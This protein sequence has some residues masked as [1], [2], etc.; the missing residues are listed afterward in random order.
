MGEMSNR[1]RLLRVLR[2]EPVDRIPVAPFIHINYVK[3]FFGSHEVDWVVKTP[4]VYK[5]FGF[6]TIHRN[7]SPVYDAYGPGTDT[8]KMKTEVQRDGR[9]ETKIT[10]ITTPGGPIRIQ[11]ELRW[12]CEYDAESSAVEYPIAGIED[13]ELFRRHQPPLEAADATDIRRA[14]DA[15]GKEGIVAPWIQGAFNLLALYYRKLDDLLLDPLVNPGFYARMMEHFLTRYMGFVQQLIDAGTDV[16]SYGANVANAKLISPEFYR[17]YIGPYEKR[18][19]DFIQSRGVIVLFHN[20][21]YARNFLSLYS[22]LGMQAY[23]SLAPRPYGDT[24][25]NEAVAAFGM[26]TALAG[27]IDQLDLLR[28]GT[29]QQIDSTVETICRTVRNRS[30]FILGTTDYFNEATPRENIHALAEAGR[31]HGGV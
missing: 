14:K 20:C 19:I 24:E 30:N 17:R 3:E 10:E 26:K 11:E 21:G 16:L 31:R 7:C 22:D 8:W 1:E 25:L 4:E 2:R 28:S 29:P 23:E 15:V 6:D 27:G 18:L 5:H 13:F 12:T 9:D